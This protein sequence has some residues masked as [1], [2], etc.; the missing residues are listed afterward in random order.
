MS[1]NHMKIFVAVISLTKTLFYLKILTKNLVMSYILYGLLNLFLSVELHSLNPEFRLNQ[2]YMPEKQT[3]NFK[4]YA[5]DLKILA[6]TSI[7]V[8]KVDEQNWN[9]LTIHAFDLSIKKVQTRTLEGDEIAC[10][11]KLVNKYETLEISLKSN[12]TRHEYL[13]IFIEYE[14]NI[15]K[16]K[17]HGIYSPYTWHSNDRNNYE[18]ELVTFLQPA[19]ARTVFPTFDEPI[20]RLK[21]SLNLE[22]YQDPDQKLG[23]VLFNSAMKENSTNNKSGVRNYIFKETV[24][25]PAYLVAIAVL[26]PEH[27]PKATEFNYFEIPIRVFALSYYYESWFQNNQKSVEKLIQIIQFTISFCE[28]RFEVQWKTSEK[29]DFVVTEM[30]GKIG[31]MEQ[32]GLIT[33]NPD[34]M[35]NGYPPHPSEWYEP[36][37]V[38]IIHE[39]VHQWTGGLLTN[40]WWDS[41][42]LNEGFTTF[43]QSEITRELIKFRRLSRTANNVKL[44]HDLQNYPVKEKITSALAKNKFDFRGFTEIFYDKA[45]KAAS[46]LNAAMGNNLMACLGIVFRKYPFSSFNSKF[47]MNQLTD[48]PYATVNVTE[49]M[50]YWLFGAKIPILRIE[51]SSQEATFSYDFLCSLVEIQN[52]SCNQ[53]TPKFDP[54]FALNFRDTENNLLQNSILLTK[55]NSKSILTFDIKIHPLFFV[56][57]YDQGNFIVAYPDNN[58]EEF[59]KWFREKIVAKNINLPPF[60]KVFVMDLFELSKQNAT[61]LKWLFEIMEEKDNL[62]DAEVLDYDSLRGFEICLENEFFPKMTSAN[63]DDELW[64]FSCKWNPSFFSDCMTKIEYLLDFRSSY[65]TKDC[66]TW[67]EM[68]GPAFKNILIDYIK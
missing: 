44:F 19:F 7:H 12:E 43:L 66:K 11:F 68:F 50:R 58:Y 13:V 31:A 60:Y 16:S 57:A 33:F 27:Y 55:N 4:Y 26:N 18:Y 28:S 10:T 47:V 54:H 41:F 64:Q 36:M 21:F 14:I 30:P 3:L 32:P 25:I 46:L 23:L 22:I 38:T 17:N 52:G 1:V 24:P 59:F 67:V 51:T 62:Y 9:K 5:R 65:V 49:F 20:F 15:E 53:E 8:K 37:Y 63:K 40:N 45:G 61:N 56:N 42:W 34:V 39:I 29:I 6:T 2:N 48:C 35:G